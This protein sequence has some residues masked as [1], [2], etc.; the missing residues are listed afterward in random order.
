MTHAF[1]RRSFLAGGIALGAGLAALGA[2]SEWAGAAFTNGP[3]ATA[4][5]RPTQARRLHHVRH[6][7]RGGRIRS[8]LGPVGRR[9]LPLRPHRVRPA[10]DRHRRRQVEPYLAQSIT[11]NPDF[12]VYTITL[13]PGIVFHDGTPLNAAALQ[14]N[15]EKQKASL[16]TGPALQSIASTQITGPLTVTITMNAPWEPFPYPGPGPDG[17]HRRPLHAQQRGWDVAPGRHRSLRLQGMDSQQPLHRHRQSPL[18]AQG[19]AVPQFDHLQAD[20]QS[21]IEGQSPCRRARSTSCTRI[22]H[23]RS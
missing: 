2:G 7:H 23:S 21:F 14:L 13:R 16:L 22:H 6:R 1:D 19:P 8:H 4:F 10:G 20:H 3:G 17:V 9:R 18:L 5:R 12:T 15:L 11:S